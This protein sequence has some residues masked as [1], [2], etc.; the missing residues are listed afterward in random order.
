MS[1]P[2]FSV[3]RSSESCLDQVSESLDTTDTA[4]I[5]STIVEEVNTIVELGEVECLQLIPNP[6]YKNRIQIRDVHIFHHYVQEVAPGLMP[7]EY[8][9]N[10]WLAYPALA[11]HY[12][13]EG[14]NHL[15]HALMAHSATT[16]ANKGYDKLNML[17]ASA[18][19]YVLAMEELRSLIAD[20][21]A[22][23]VSS[24]TTIMT[25]MFTEVGHENLYL[26]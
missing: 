2:P 10:P 13:G 12:S 4:E 6:R 19:Y 3:F 17:A 8:S 16:L 26:I 15:L 1:C 9:R 20:T 25:L 11:L 22:D 18:R 14:R 21:S 23:Y 24:L 5:S 7:Y